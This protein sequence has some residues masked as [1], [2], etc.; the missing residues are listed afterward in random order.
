[1][2]GI[3]VGVVLLIAILTIVMSGIF[4]VVFSSEAINLKTSLKSSEVLKY[5]DFV[6]GVKRGL[7]YSYNYSF[8]QIAYELGKRGGYKD[9]ESISEWRRYD[10][11]YFPYTYIDCLENGTEK[12]IGEYIKRLESL[13]KEFSFPSPDVKIRLI[14]EDRLENVEMLVRSPHLF[15]Y[16]KYFFVIYDNPNRTIYLPLD[17]FKLY[18]FSYEIFIEKDSIREII[19]DTEYKIGKD[20]GL[21]DKNVCRDGKI[22]KKIS[23]YV[24]ASAKEDGETVLK[25]VCPDAD[26]NFN[27]SVVKNIEDMKVDDESL[28]L[29]VKVLNITVKHRYWERSNVAGCC[30]WY[31]TDDGSCYCV[32]YLL[33]VT[34]YYNYY[35]AIKVGVNF[36]T[37]N[38]YPVYDLLQRSTKFRR[39]ALLFNLTTGNDYAWKPI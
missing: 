12:Y 31:C 35:A 26:V 3:F 6:E 5:V 21:W 7:D 13:E 8:Y 37:T 4:L 39:F 27:N 14:G 28:D 23:G 38:K 34:Y 36:T 32:D 25:R 24:C 9:E 30:R 29:R 19:N 15:N 11:I 1:M 2:K 10:Q 20:C 22:C 16:S 17:Y 18:N 33:H